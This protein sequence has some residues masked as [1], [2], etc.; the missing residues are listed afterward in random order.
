[1]IKTIKLD[2]KVYHNLDDIRVK[3]ETYSQAVERLLRIRAS[4]VDLEQH[5]RAFYARP[6]IGGC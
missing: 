4:I 2:V 6:R 5:V 3:G 1:M